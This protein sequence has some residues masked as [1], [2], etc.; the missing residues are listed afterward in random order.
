MLLQFPFVFSIFI[1]LNL[2]GKCYKDKF[3]PSDDLSINSMSFTSLIIYVY[4]SR[5]YIL[6]R[7]ISFNLIDWDLNPNVPRLDY[8]EYD[9]LKI[10]MYLKFSNSCLA[11]VYSSSNNSTGDRQHILFAIYEINVTLNELL[12]STL[13]FRQQYIRRYVVHI[14]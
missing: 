8:Y 12:S 1:T 7:E 11:K 2:Q 9:V 3:Q 14:D 6:N 13:Y 5:C 10:F 4:K